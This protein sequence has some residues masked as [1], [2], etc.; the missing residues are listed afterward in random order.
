MKNKLVC[1]TTAAAIAAVAQPSLAGVIGISPNTDFDAATDFTDDFTNNGGAGYA[2]SVTAGVGD[3]GGLLGVNNNG[4]PTFQTNAS[5]Q[6]QTDTQTISGMFLFDDAGE[7]AAAASVRA[8]VGTVN[9]GGN[10]GEFRGINFQIRNAGGSNDFTARLRTRGNTVGTTVSPFTLTDDHWYRI[11]ASFTLAGD[12]NSFTYDFA[13]YDF[14][15]DGET[16]L[17]TVFSL[18][19][20]LVDSSGFTFDPN[21]TRHLAFIGTVDGNGYGFSE[22]DNIGSDLADFSAIPEPASASLLLIGGA[23]IAARRRRS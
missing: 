5:T 20:V 2:H 8:G 15:T 11:D 14:G 13:V 21:N 4:A 23:L 22:I 1:I 19:D 12:G 18:D 10:S 9:G 6:F 3:T 16:F 7:T 17:G